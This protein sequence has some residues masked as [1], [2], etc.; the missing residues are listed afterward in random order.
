[1]YCCLRERFGT[2]ASTPTASGENGLLLAILATD[3]LDRGIVIIVI[4]VKIVRPLGCIVIMA[5]VCLLN[6]GTVLA[7]SAPLTLVILL[8][9]GRC[10]RGLLRLLRLVC[11]TLY[12]KVLLDS[13]HLIGRSALGGIQPTVATG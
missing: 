8:D 10:R 13:E 1:M 4:I 3:A 6:S 7:T 2:G 9:T 5:R 12:L 11:A